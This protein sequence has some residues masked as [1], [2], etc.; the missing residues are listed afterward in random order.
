MPRDIFIG[1]TGYLEGEQ[2]SGKF[3]SGKHG[4]GIF[5]RQRAEHRYINRYCEGSSDQAQREYTM[6]GNDGAVD[7][8][9]RFWVGTM[10]DPSV[11]PPTDVGKACS[12]LLDSP[13]NGQCWHLQVLSF[14][15]SQISPCESLERI[16]TSHLRRKKMPANFRNRPNSKVQRSRFTLASR[17][18]N[19]MASEGSD[20]A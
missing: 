17:G 9:G 18:R 4:H 13:L 15:W 3:V 12:K 5:D 7:S 19:C 2:A 10:R 20:N 16:C 6:R 8:K 1:S 14:V 11:S